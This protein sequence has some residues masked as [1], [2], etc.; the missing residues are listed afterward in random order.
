MQLP[1][2]PPPPE[3]MPIAAM[4]QEIVLAQR[5]QTVII[6]RID[7]ELAELRT[8]VHDLT[9]AVDIVLG[10]VTRHGQAISPCRSCSNHG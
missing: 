6:G 1:S 2:F 8:W 7:R 3:T 5:E 10:E 4:L 9:T